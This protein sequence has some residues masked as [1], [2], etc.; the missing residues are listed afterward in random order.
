MEDLAVVTQ[1]HQSVRMKLLS[2]QRTLGLAV[3]PLGDTV[4]AEQVTTGRGRAVPP[5]LQTE[6][7]ASLGAHTALTIRAVGCGL[8]HSPLA[9]GRLFPSEVVELQE[10][11]EEQLEQGERPQ[12]AVTGPDGTVVS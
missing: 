8:V 11:C 4:P 10:H 2:T 1:K 5:W 7:T 12:Q 3:A 6:D 9:P